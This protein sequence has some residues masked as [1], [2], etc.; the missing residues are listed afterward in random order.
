M[1]TLQELEKVI[2]SAKQEFGELEKEFI[3]YS[4]L[5]NN[6]NQ[7]YNYEEMKKIANHLLFCNSKMKIKESEFEKIK[8]SVNLGYGFH[9]IK[10]EITHESLTIVLGY[11]IKNKGWRLELIDQ[12]NKHIK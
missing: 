6:Y 9:T 7:I 2:E 5:S 3:G 8:E 1:N 11:E 10:N 4:F 12:I